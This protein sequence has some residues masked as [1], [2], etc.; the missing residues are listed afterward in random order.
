MDSLLTLNQMI[1]LSKVII[2]NY[3]LYGET[4]DTV[5]LE[6]IRS[7]TGLEDDLWQEM[8][9]TESRANSLMRYMDID[10][11]GYEYVGDIKSIIGD[12]NS[13]E[14]QRVYNYLVRYMNATYVTKLIK[15][16]EKMQNGGYDFY[17][18]FAMSR[19]SYKEE[20]EDL[21]YS[22]Y[23]YLMI[24]IE[25]IHK[26]D[27]YLNDN[28]VKRYKK[29]LR[30]LKYLLIG[31]NKLFDD[32][33]DNIGLLF[34]PNIELITDGVI[35]NDDKMISACAYNDLT[36]LMGDLINEKGYKLLVSEMLMEIAKK[37]V[38][39][40]WGDVVKL[41]DDLQESLANSKK[42]RR[43]VEKIISGN[44]G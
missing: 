19:D 7:L 29:E 30:K 4:N 33:A 38:L 5:Y 28:N 8:Q 40:Q 20:V 9:L 14:R 31:S 16:R 27:N 13:Y 34:W 15:N 12:K 11:V 39:D 26:I 2:E 32:Y 6:K 10:G 3:A 21:L 35:L 23:Y 1:E 17:G 25:L 43:I 22:E 36:W 44:D 24:I 42:K 41:G 18:D 37:Y